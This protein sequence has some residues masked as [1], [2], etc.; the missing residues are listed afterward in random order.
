M[1]GCEQARS[2]TSSSRGG[3]FACSTRTKI[4]FAA[5]VAVQLALYGLLTLLSQQFGFYTAGEGRPLLSFYAIMAAAF[6]AYLCSIPLALRLDDSTRSIMIFVAVAVAARAIVLVSEPIQE[7]DIYRYIWDGAVSGEGISPYRFPPLEI[8]EAKKGAGT[9]GAERLFGQR[10]FGVATLAG[11]WESQHNHRERDGNYNETAIF[12]ESVQSG[13]VHLEGRSEL[14]RLALLASEQQGLG[15]VLRRVHFSELPTVYP[16]V[17]QAV[18]RF[19]DWLTP[20]DAG[21]TTRVRIMKGV[22]VLCDVGVMLMLLGLLRSLNLHCGWSIAYGWS[23][24]VIKEFANSG[25]LDSIAIFLV[26]ASIFVLT[27]ARSGRIGSACILGSGLLMGLGVGAKLYPL[28]LFPLV[29][30]FV[31]KVRGL[32]LSIAWSVLA[33]LAT[34]VSVLPMAVRRLDAEPPVLAGESSEQLQG[35]T[36]FLSRWEINDLLFMVIEENIRPE[37]SVEGQ[38]HLW[39]AIMP[40]SWRNRLTATASRIFHSDGDSERTPFLLTRALTTFAWMVIALLLCRRVWRD[41]ATFYESAFLTLAWFWFLS[42]TQNPWYWIWAL[43]LVPWARNRTW[44]LVSG[45]ILIYYSRFWFQ[46]HATTTAEWGLP[47]QGVAIFDFFVVWIEFAPFLLLLFLSI[48][49]SRKN[50]S[51]VALVRGCRNVTMCP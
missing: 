42:P 46:Y 21:V 22:I 2:A 8:Q 16:P 3:W 4:W 20:I 25:H 18:F 24:L 14:D 51:I 11:A 23:P 45:L 13:A 47:Y 40:D 39:F 31:W 29:A 12:E 19:S 10:H 49:I 5:L 26:V 44:L 37:A 1:S 30:C 36:T 43:P 38:P 28:V 9:N 41:P 15:E 7:V 32:R 34:V 6:A 17:S 50:S 48:S 27:I 33:C 35:L